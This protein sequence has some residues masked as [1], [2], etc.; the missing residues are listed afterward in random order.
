MYINNAIAIQN[1][2]SHFKNLKYS[3]SMNFLIFRNFNPLK[4]T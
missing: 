2:I 4:A 3:L 1:S